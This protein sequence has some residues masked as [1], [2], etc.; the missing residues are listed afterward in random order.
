MQNKVNTYAEQVAT[1][2]IEALEKGT[3]PWIKP[4]K[5]NDLLESIPLNPITNKKYK[6]INFINLS[7]EQIRNDYNDPRWLTYKQAESIGAQV[8][9]GE[10]G[11]S[12][13]YWKFSEEVEL[14]DEQGNPILDEKG[15]P[16][17]EEVRLDPPQVFYA[18]V[19]NARQVNGMPP[20]ERIDL[21]VER[22][23]EAIEAVERILKNSGADITHKE[24]NRAFY[25]PS[26]DTI[27]LPLKEQF[28]SEMAYYS[29]A[30]HELGHWT[31]HE[32]RLNREFGDIFG[33]D[34]YAREELRAEI[35]SYMLCS[36]LG[37]DFD[38]SNHHA[39]ISS[40]VESLKDTPLEI[41]KAS[42]DAVKIENY[43]QGFNRMNT[44]EQTAEQDN[45]NLK[46]ETNNKSEL[47]EPRSNRSEALANED[48][49]FRSSRTS[50]GTQDEET[51][52]HKKINRQ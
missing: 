24:G 27:T 43:L 52:N 21:S 4:W 39:Y 34:T 11:V 29:T 12:I 15:K 41:F 46:D 45:S 35:A 37:V 33:S 49:T 36:E 32:S 30:L 25:T 16:K 50:T 23:F 42:A 17:K 2:I 19:F 22:E 13:Q 31:G 44:Q 9:K 51:I 5:G 3:A 1:K 6:G 14:K 48:C 8:R 20:I 10:K 18:T 26:K 40:W 28:S 47:K 7:M 38:P